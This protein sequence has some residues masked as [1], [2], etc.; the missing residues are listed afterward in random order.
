M[1][2]SKTP[3]FPPFAPP[4]TAET[5]SLYVVGNMPLFYRHKVYGVGADIEVADSDAPSM[6]AYISPK[7]Q[8]QPEP[9]PAAA[10]PQATEPAP[11]RKPS[12]KTTRS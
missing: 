9:L 4:G 10:E 8:P 11:A 6:A 2:A 5:T 12:A 3:A 7:P 1:A